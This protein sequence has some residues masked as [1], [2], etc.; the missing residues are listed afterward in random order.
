MNKYKNESNKYYCPKINRIAKINF[1]YL[2][3]YNPITDQVIKEIKIS[4]D[5][6]KKY[7]CRICKESCNLIS[8]NWK[9]C[10]NPQCIYS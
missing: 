8:F 5:C 2:L 10:A 6:D 7:K 3:I 4:F 1:K 9:E